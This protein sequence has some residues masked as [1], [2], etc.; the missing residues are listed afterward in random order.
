MLTK[1]QMQEIL[2]IM[3]QVYKEAGREVQTATLVES[4]DKEGNISGEVLLDKR[5]DEEL[6]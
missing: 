1:E 4:I 2:E 6:N 5:K 3:Q